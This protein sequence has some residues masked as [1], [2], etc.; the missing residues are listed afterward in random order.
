VQ[1]DKAIDDLEGLLHG[2]L[3]EVERGNFL[4][5][6]GVKVPRRIVLVG[7]HEVFEGVLARGVL[8]VIEAEVERVHTA[9]VRE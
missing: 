6:A 4:K 2:P 8:E 5:V 3:F 9:P 1:L 7:G